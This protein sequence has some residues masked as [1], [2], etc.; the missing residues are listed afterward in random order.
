MVF[1]VN[2][3]TSEGPVDEV[4]ERLLRPFRFRESIRVT[5]DLEEVPID[6]FL[7]T[8]CGLGPQLLRLFT[9]RNVA[10]VPGVVQ[11]PG[12]DLTEEEHVVRLGRKCQAKPLNLPARK[13]AH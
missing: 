2:R 4:G 1:A 10:S 5:C 11:V 3:P 9:P 12:R 7:P 8:A 6:S 13:E